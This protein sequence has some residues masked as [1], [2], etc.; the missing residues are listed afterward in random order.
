[1]FFVLKKGVFRHV[2][3]G[4]G[5]AE[6]MRYTIC[7]IHIQWVEVECI[8]V[9]GSTTYLRRAQL[10]RGFGL[11]YIPSTVELQPTSSDATTPEEVTDP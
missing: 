7:I 10:L 1:V 3:G 6:R 9:N 5:I 8:P 2:G 4:G 11:V